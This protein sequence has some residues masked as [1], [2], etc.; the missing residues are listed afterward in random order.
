MKIE[1]K[2]YRYEKIATESK[3]FELP[4]EPVYF[5]ETGIRRAI[6][7]IPEFTT[8]QVEMQ[9]KPEE[10][11]S[12]KITCV[13]LSWECKIVHFGIAVGELENNLR[14]SSKGYYAEFVQNWTKGWFH[15]RTKEQFDADLASA[16]NKINS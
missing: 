8:W 13:H 1:L 16:F 11:Y 15:K 4:E 12:F 5:F 14:E 7:I 6:R 2:Q 3:D 9:N 10:L